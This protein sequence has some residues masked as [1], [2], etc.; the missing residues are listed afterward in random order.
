MNVM[1]TNIASKEKL[2]WYERSWHNTFKVI[3]HVSCSK[4]K[5]I[6]YVKI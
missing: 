4:N 5:K 6:S 2:M 3:S 1:L